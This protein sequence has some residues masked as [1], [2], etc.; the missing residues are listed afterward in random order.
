MVELSAKTWTFQVDEDDVESE[1]FRRNER[2]KDGGDRKHG[3]ANFEKEERS[4]PSE[5]TAPMKAFANG[6]AKQVDVSTK[7]SFPCFYERSKERRA[8]HEHV[9]TTSTFA[10]MVD[11]LDEFSPRVII[12]HATQCR[13]HDCP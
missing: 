9:S 12:D 8:C 13:F 2:R 6:T 4:R 1:F 11:D 10:F 5:W 3:T 7:E